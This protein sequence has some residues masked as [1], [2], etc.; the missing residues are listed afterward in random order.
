MLE[1]QGGYIK[2]SWYKTF[3]FSVEESA[4]RFVVQLVL[5]EIHIRSSPKIKERSL[6]YQRK[7][8]FYCKY[9]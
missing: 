6:R 3:S 7:L 9:V 4:R 8:L 2:F 5:C 1:N